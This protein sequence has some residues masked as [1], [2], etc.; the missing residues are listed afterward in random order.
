MIGANG[1]NLKL[2]DKEFKIVNKY[3]KKMYKKFLKPVEF[4]KKDHWKI[5]QMANG[6]TSKIYSWT[7]N[8]KLAAKEINFRLKQFDKL[9]YDDGYINNNSFRGYRSMVPLLWIKYNSELCLCLS[10]GF[11]KFQIN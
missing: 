4:E 3:I 11:L 6:G 9:I 7:N 2:N 10:Y 5:Y 8:K 1:L